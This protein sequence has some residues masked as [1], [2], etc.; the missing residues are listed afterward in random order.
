MQEW[1]FQIALQEMIKYA[2]KKARFQPHWGV[3]TDA[4]KQP[5]SCQ[6]VSF[7]HHQFKASHCKIFWAA[8]TQAE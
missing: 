7:G 1:N 4:G 6:H 2:E 3:Q 5:T 8:P